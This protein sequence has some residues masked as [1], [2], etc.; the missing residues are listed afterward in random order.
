MW[1]HKEEKMKTLRNTLLSAVAVILIG[2]ICLHADD[3][4]ARGP[5]SFLSVVT[6]YGRIAE[7]PATVASAATITLPSGTTFW[8]TGTT[9]I[10]RI[11]GGVPG[12]RVNLVFASTGDSIPNGVNLSLSAT[13]VSTANEGITMIYGA[14]GAASDTLWRIN[15]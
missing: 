15:R 12:Q 13:F 3:I 8:I 14:N 11:L 9:K 1:P 7:T 10:T 4:V 2:V 5:R 6:F